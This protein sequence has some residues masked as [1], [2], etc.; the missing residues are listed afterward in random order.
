MGE[1]S[2]RRKLALSGKPECS[3]TS[4]LALAASGTG[5]QSCVVYGAWVESPLGID[6][7]QLGTMNLKVPACILQYVLHSL[8]DITG[9]YFTDCQVSLIRHGDRKSHVFHT[10]VTRLLSRT[11]Y[12]CLIPRR[13]LGEASSRR[14]LALSGKPECSLTS[15]LAL[16]AS[17]TGF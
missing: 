3:L 13:L 11:T 2:S 5:F 14:K 1:A 17:G 16:A 15:R 10:H 4:R 12:S 9:R 6:T 8:R 7:C